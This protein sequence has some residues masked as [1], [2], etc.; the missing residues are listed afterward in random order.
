MYE[1]DSLS[2][3]LVH[4]ADSTAN[5]E[6]LKCCRAE[7]DANMQP[8]IFRDDSMMTDENVPFEISIL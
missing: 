6:P 8:L 1:L 7:S 3:T 4:V 2:S 5:K